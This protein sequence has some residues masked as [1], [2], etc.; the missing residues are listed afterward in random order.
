MTSMNPL[1]K[2]SPS[3]DFSIG[4]TTWEDDRNYIKNIK[5][6][7][8]DNEKKI[9]NDYALN[10]DGGTGLGDHSVTSRFGQYNLFQFINKLPDLK[11]LLNFFQFSYLSF[12]KGDNAEIEDCEIVC[13][14]N[15]VRN[16]QSINKHH[17]GAGH[18]VY[19]SGNFMCDDYPTQTIYECPFDSKVIFPIQNKK[20]NLTLFPTCLPHYS[21]TF[22]SK[23]D[24]R[25]SIA[26]DIRLCN[27]E[28]AQDLNAIPFI[29]HDILK[30][31]KVNTT[32]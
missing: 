21:S 22:E 28:R 31:L 23:N 9:I 7:L 13:W 24:C 30:E 18:D 17:H 1:T 8:I 5:E 6:W 25:V 3:W 27:I 14:F 32:D 12:V 10:F 29:N 19:L 2:Y 16:N 15:I 4:L 20:G 26:F 11:K